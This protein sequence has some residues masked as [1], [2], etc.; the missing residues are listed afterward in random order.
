MV[1]TIILEC[2]FSALGF[3]GCSEFHLSNGEEKKRS[4]IFGLL[5]SIC[6]IHYG[7]FPTDLY[8][9]TLKNCMTGGG[10]FVVV[11]ILFVCLFVCFSVFKSEFQQNP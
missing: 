1:R 4:I 11:F 5:R 7:C 3:Y 8:F 6:I 10:F 9:A 2:L